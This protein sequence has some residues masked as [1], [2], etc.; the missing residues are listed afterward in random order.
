MRRT[1][2]AVEH[3]RNSKVPL[4]RETAE[5]SFGTCIVARCHTGNRVETFA[6]ELSAFLNEV[7]AVSDT[8][9]RV[10]KVQAEKTTDKTGDTV[11]ARNGGG[12][13]QG[14]EP[15][16]RA[17]ADPEPAALLGSDGWQ[18]EDFLTNFNIDGFETDVEVQDCI[19]G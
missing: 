16:E 1:S 19:V 2:H 8:R 7:G 15:V 17:Q 11:E 9:N 10:R 18:L 5:Q 12:E 3:D 6:G 13:N 4:L 14:Q